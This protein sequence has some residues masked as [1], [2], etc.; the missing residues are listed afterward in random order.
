MQANATTTCSC[1]FGLH[2]YDIRV[3]AGEVVW[4]EGYRTVR[5]KHVVASL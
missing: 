2:N 5:Q 4:D 1:G 3:P